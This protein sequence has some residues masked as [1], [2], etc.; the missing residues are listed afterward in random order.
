MRHIIRQPAWS[1]LLRGLIAIFVGL[2]ALFYP[3][4]TLSIFVILLGIYIFANGILAMIFSFY[5]R[6]Y[7]DKHWWIYG[8]EGLLG[9]LVGII[10]FTWPIMTTIAL[11]YLVATWAIITGIIQIIAYMKLHKIFEH[12]MLILLAGILS[13]VFG[14]F[15]FK[16]P[17]AGLITATWIVGFYALIYGFLALASAFRTK[18]RL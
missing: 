4:M 12:E 10:V 17:T 8:I 15:F 14:I 13:I 3:T 5:D 1:L 9:L 7:Q 16:F 6:Q 18:R 2:F 11:I